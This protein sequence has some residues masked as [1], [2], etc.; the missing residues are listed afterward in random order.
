ML[1]GSIH[2]ASLGTLYQCTA[3]RIG[4][5]STGLA[6]CIRTGDNESA[7]TLELQSGRLIA[8]AK[9]LEI[10]MCER[11]VLLSKDDLEHCLEALQPLRC[12]VNCSVNRTRAVELNRLHNKLSD[13]VDSL[14]HEE[15]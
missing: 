6:T 9:K 13:A 7:L 12:R 11:P 8:L 15:Y 1:S 14:E 2:K 4:A 5:I 3:E 10:A